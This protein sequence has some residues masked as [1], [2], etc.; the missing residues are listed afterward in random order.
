MCSHCIPKPNR[1]FVNARSRV[2]STAIF[3]TGTDVSQPTYLTLLSLLRSV[4]L[5]IEILSFCGYP[6]LALSTGYGIYSWGKS[7]YEYLN[8]KAG[9]VAALEHGEHWLLASG[10]VPKFSI[11]RRC[12]IAPASKNTFAHFNVALI[13]PGTPDGSLKWLLAKYCGFI[14]VVMM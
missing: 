3:S 13:P 14:N 9:H 11:S 10:Q 7:H 4:R 12:F 5:R 6:Y 8:S 2:L 1:H